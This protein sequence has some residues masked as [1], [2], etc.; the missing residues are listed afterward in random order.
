MLGRCCSAAGK[1]T[2]EEYRPKCLQSWP[3]HACGAGSRLLR[4]LAARSPAADPGPSARAVRR[5]CWIPRLEF[6]HANSPRNGT[7]HAVQQRSD[8]SAVSWPNALLN[9]DVPLASGLPPSKP[10]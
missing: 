3:G 2:N 5:P 4:E 6:V 1:G 7:G 8:H 10:C 9:G